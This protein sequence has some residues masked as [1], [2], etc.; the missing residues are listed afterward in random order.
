[1]KVR[2]L[3][4][5]TCLSQLPYLTP[6]PTTHFHLSLTLFDRLLTSPYFSFLS[7]SS[8][9][10]SVKH[11]SS[12]LQTLQ[13]VPPCH[14]LHHY[15]SGNVTGKSLGTSKHLHL[16]FEV[17][18][19]ILLVSFI[20]CLRLY[21]Y[22]SLNNDTHVIFEHWKWYLCVYMYGFCIGGIIWWV[23]IWFVLM[24]TT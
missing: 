20:F 15:F 2:F 5:L 19:L 10:F 23:A 14:H 6:L 17:K 7:F 21:F 22:L 1:M 11:S 9:A 3:V 16:L 8:F 4:G 24:M 18:F 12:F 13:L